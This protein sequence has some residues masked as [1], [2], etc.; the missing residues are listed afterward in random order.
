[1]RKTSELQH[2]YVSRKSCGCIDSICVTDAGALRGFLNDLR[3]EGRSAELIELKKAKGEEGF[4][5]CPHEGAKTKGCR[6]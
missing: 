5:D 2:A 4:F 3:A 6:S 1:M